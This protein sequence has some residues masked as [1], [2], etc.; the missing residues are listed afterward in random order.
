MIDYLANCLMLQQ[1]VPLMKKNFSNRRTLGKIYLFSKVVL[2]LIIKP[3][4]MTLIYSTKKMMK[5]STQKVVK[6]NLILC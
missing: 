1:K 4:E 5:K 3:N 2:T 6:T